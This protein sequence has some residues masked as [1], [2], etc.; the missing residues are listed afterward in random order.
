MIYVNFFVDVHPMSQFQFYDLVIW[1]SMNKTPS[2]IHI[3]S[4][5]QLTKVFL[6]R[7]YQNIQRLKG[8]NMFK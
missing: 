2:D 8:G 1:L 4:A 7:T 5:E 3:S 6:E